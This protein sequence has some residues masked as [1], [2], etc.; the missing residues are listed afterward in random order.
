MH[1]L[2]HIVDDEEC[3]RDSLKA[4]LEVVGWKAA[5]FETA[6]EYLSARSQPDAEQPL[7]LLLDIQLPDMN[8]FD[9]LKEL[10]RRK[11]SVPTIV[12]TGHGDE[13]LSARAAEQNAVGYF[14]K[15]FNTSTLLKAISDILA[16]AT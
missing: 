16:Q 9:L 1:S 15:P 3:V 13:S 10:D 8:G 5:G 14:Q 6:S 12:I 2:I 11:A 7:C 4:L